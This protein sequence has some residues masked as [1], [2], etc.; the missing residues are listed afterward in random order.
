MR[1]EEKASEHLREL[2]KTTQKSGLEICAWLWGFELQAS[3]TWQQKYKGYT[4]KSF[5]PT[6][7]YN[8]TST[9]ISA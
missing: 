2:E 8:K 6:N 3:S 1:L 5:K 4:T 9:F 7:F